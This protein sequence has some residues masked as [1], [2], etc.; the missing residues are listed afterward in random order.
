MTTLKLMETKYK[1]MSVEIKLFRII[2]D[3]ESLE[4]ILKRLIR[5]M[6]IDEMKKLLLSQTY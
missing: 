4:N 3:S 1:I 2:S 6:D 5:I